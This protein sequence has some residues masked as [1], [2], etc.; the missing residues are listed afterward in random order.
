MLRGDLPP[1]LARTGHH[2]DAVRH[3][4]E[5]HHVARHDER[6]AVQDHHVG[7]LLQPLP[8][9]AAW[10][11]SP[12]A[13][14]V[15]RWCCRS[16]ARRPAGSST[17]SGTGHA[18]ND[19]PSLS[20][21]RSSS[22]RPGSS[23][24]PNISWIAGRRRSQE[25]TSTRLPACA[26]AAA[27][28]AATVV[29]PSRASAL[30]T[31]I[32]VAPSAPLPFALL[33]SVVL[34]P[35][36]LDEAERVR[37]ARIRMRRRHHALPAP[38]GDRR[39]PQRG[40]ASRTPP[41]PA[42]V[43][44]IRVSNRSSRSASTIPT[45]SPSR[46]ASSTRDLVLSGT[47]SRPSVSATSASPAA[48]GP[49]R[50]RL[51]LELRQRDRRGLLRP[52]VG[53]AGRAVPD[54]DRPGAALHR[55]RPPAPAARAAPGRSASSAVASGRRSVPVRTRPR[56][57]GRTRSRFPIPV[58]AQESRRRIDRRFHPGKQLLGVVP[59]ST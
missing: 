2:H 13:R 23:A 26:Y 54:R 25:T 19:P 6:R 32:V 38:D 14:S 52:R 31:R 29:F 22:V 40:R 50:R 46:Q 43:E 51:A 59:G 44:R 33:P 12:G 35:A 20:I 41:R 55:A 3:R 21:D 17:A 45:R 30:V 57:S 18:S 42:S 4:D 8:R 28:F 58:I 37:R 7:D 11:R 24:T 48:S 15:D 16:A 36:H 39:G 56:S 27:R 47:H 49:W 10:R 9:A 5:R 34:R 53:R 1:G